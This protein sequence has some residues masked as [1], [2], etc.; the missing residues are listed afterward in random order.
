[1][2]AVKTVL[3]IAV[4]AAASLASAN[5]ASA[6]AGWA[7]GTAFDSFAI[8][9][10]R[11][12]SL[13]RICRSVDPAYP[14]IHPGKSRDAWSACAIGFNYGEQYARS[15]ETLR[16]SWEPQTSPGL[17][18]RSSWDSVVFCRASLGGGLHVGEKHPNDDACHIAFGGKAERVTRYEVLTS[19]GGFGYTTI[20]AGNFDAAL[21]AGREADN[22][23]LYACVVQG[24]GGQAGKIRRDWRGCHIATST[25]ETSIDRYSLVA[26]HFLSPELVPIDSTRPIYVGGRDVN[27][28]VLGVCVAW[29]ENSTHAGKYR[30]SGN[31]CN[32]GYDGKEVPLTVGFSVLRAYHKF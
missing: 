12:G 7:A 19:R 14:G 13:L 23:P 4:L 6:Q 9:R 17:N 8:G 29:F 25:G 5:T 22:T 27:G 20:P 10:D 31:T 11:D 28:E 18:F 24:E 26:P 30:V 3:S 15:Y 32:I 16:P 21:I 1:M 2:I